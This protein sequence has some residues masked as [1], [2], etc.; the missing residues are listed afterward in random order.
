MKHIFYTLIFLTIPLLAFSQ[1]IKLSSEFK[2]KLLAADL[3]FV[4][5]VESD[6]KD[7]FILKN[8]LQPYDFAIRSRK[9][10]LEI[11]YIIEPFDES[12]PRASLPSMRFV[13]LLMHLATND[14]EELMA[15]HDIVPSD[16]ELFNANWGKYAFFKLKE[17]FS[18]SSN[19][20]LLSLHKVGSGTVHVLFIYK[21]PTIAL[22]NRFFAL[23]FKE[24][25]NQ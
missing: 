6:Y 21:E 3:D 24:I 12:D 8:D 20:K 1:N 19:C 4:V 16:L 22:D 15:I 9:E 13:Q 2:S 17:G 18:S 14:Q 5:P 10:Q 25:K 7:I 11:R 23:Q